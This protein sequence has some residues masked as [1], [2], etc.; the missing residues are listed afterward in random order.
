MPVTPSA[1]F[2][3]SSLWL[4]SLLASSWTYAG[5]PDQSRTFSERVEVRVVNLE[6]VV[7]DKDGKRVSGLGAGDFR[8]RVDGREVPIDYFS[9]IAEGRAVEA[10]AAGGAG[11]HAQGTA[12]APPAGIEPGRPVGTSYLVFIDDFLTFRASDRN[13]VLAKIRDRLGDLGPEDRMAIVAFDGRRLDLLSDWSG[14]QE[15]LGRA[16]D[17]AE[18]RPLHGLFRRAVAGADRPAAVPTGAGAPQGGGQGASGGGGGEG[19]ALVVGSGSADAFG[20]NDENGVAVDLCS[21][22]HRTEHYLRKTVV[23]ATAAL[24]SFAEPPGRGVMLLLSG[25]WPNSVRDYLAG[26]VAPQP[27]AQCT[28]EGPRLYRPIYDTAN[29]LGYTLYPVD[30]PGPSTS[31]V[32]AATVTST[33]DPHGFGSNNN[34]VNSEF[35]LHTTLLKLAA[36]T[37]GE[38]MI[39]AA[40]QTALERVVDDTRSYYWL[41]FTPSWQ[42]DD[43]EHKIDLD[44]RPAGLK[45]RSRSGFQDLSRATEVSFKVESALLFDNPP[46]VKPLA[47]HLGE[48]G[49]GS[50]PLVPVEVT[51]PMDEVTMVPKGNHYAARLELR[52]AV[53]DERGNQNEIAAIPVDLEGP[54]PPPGSHALYDTKVR[55]RRARQEMVI[56]LYD[57]LSDN[58]LVGKTIFS[59]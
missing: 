34:D 56:S 2:A 59:P 36:E 32:S 20:L 35:E 22:I 58:L 8:L 10:A 54:A 42:G 37:G 48:A 11:G 47:V 7:V 45:V 29:L 31:G 51:I 28:A 57:P 39:D 23:A 40:R 13:L 24:R 1:R 16:I 50:R 3:V 26:D 4:A 25:G 12:P 38:A 17:A 43:K 14:S 5:T 49:R 52:V 6:A 46:G 21:R 18:A 44:A 30:L 9:E 53:L 55:L 19:K 33:D 27:S 15:E 41:G